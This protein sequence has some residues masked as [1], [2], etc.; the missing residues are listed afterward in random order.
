MRSLPPMRSSTS[1]SRRAP[2]NSMNDQT[3]AAILP[4]SYVPGFRFARPD[5]AC[6]RNCRQATN[7]SRDLGP[8]E[9]PGPF[10]E[11][12]RQPIAFVGYGGL[13][14]VG[15]SDFTYYPGACLTL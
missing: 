6:K 7:Q 13:G 8:S 5:C 1:P 3:T 4:S 10:V 2:A 11:W 14:V 12:Q 9:I 15:H